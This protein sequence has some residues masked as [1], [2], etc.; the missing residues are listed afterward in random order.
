MLKQCLIVFRVRNCHN[1]HSSIASSLYPGRSVFKN[2]TLGWIY[3]RLSWS[4]YTST[5][6]LVVPT[7]RHDANKYDESNRSYTVLTSDLKST[8]LAEKRYHSHPASLLPPEKCRG[9]AYPLSRSCHRLSRTVR[10]TEQ[11]MQCEQVACWY[12]PVRGA[13]TGNH[14]PKTAKHVLVT[15]YLQVESFTVRTGS[16]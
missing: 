9:P 7:R 11:A 14:M 4:A 8:S 13:S 15:H 6:P 1:I 10:F 5:C 2:Q 3:T 12:L 16:W